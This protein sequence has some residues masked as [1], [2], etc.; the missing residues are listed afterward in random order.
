MQTFFTTRDILTNLEI[1]RIKVEYKCREPL[2]YLGKDFISESSINAFDFLEKPFY[3]NRTAE[4]YFFCGTNLEEIKNIGNK[5]YII[6][7]EK[8]SNL[9]IFQ[10]S[11]LPIF[12]N[13][14]ERDS[15]KI[16]FHN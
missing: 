5:K 7:G 14:L 10:D 16:K 11:T 3:I 15:F 8:P 12:K 9:L 4:V 2:Y 1:Q 13:L 6:I